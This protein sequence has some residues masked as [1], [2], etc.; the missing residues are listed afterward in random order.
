MARKAKATK[1]TESESKSRGGNKR[2]AA[3][4]IGHN[5]EPDEVKKKKFLEN[6]RPRWIAATTTLKTLE[7]E[8][9][10]AIGKHA[11][12]DLR[13]SVEIVTPEGEARIKERRDAELRVARWM[14]VALG[15]Q[16]E[17]FADEID[18][19]PLN[20]VERAYEAGKRAGLE[21]EKRTSNYTPGTEAEQNWMKGWHDG[22]EALL[23]HGLHGP[24]PD[25]VAIEGED[26]RD[27]RPA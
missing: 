12:R 27:L 22:Q 8:I 10:T 3:A 9:K 14:G 1:A 24:A 15:T 23:R 11:I 16:A 21:G 4:G 2:I 5:G 13:L 26:E 17:M 20:D 6:F 25:P 19:Q 18:Q 7:E